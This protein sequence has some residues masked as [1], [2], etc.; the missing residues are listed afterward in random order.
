MRF[1]ARRRLAAALVPAC[2]LACGLALAAPDPANEL[3]AQMTASLHANVAPAFVLDK[4]LVLDPALREAADKIGAEHLARVD[5]LFPAWLEEERSRQVADGK[6]PSSRDVFYA[7]FA[8]LMN[9]MSLWQ[10]EPGDP[11]YERATL[12]VLRTAAGVCDLQGDDRFTDFASRILR[13][14]AMPPAQRDAA[15]GTER[16][17]L[18][19]WGQP[20]AALAPWPDPLPQDA[21]LALLERGPADPAHPR[22][23]LTPRMAAGVLGRREDY[24]HMHPVERCGLQQWWL[25]QSLREGTAPTTALN[26]F[27]YGTMLT[28]VD[29][30]GT[31]FD[32][33][34]QDDKPAPGA[35]PRYPAIALRFLATGVNTVRLQ[36]DAD[37]R[38]KPSVVERR[39]EVVGIRGV[40]PV[41]FENVF[42]Q[43]LLTFAAANPG[44]FPKPSDATP[45]KFQ[46]VWTLEDD[47]P[48]AKTG[49]KP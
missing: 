12:A 15:L 6:T 47:K 37:G 29:R 44:R 43:A 8:R 41:A 4:A 2:A 33:A 45:P 18:A 5:K 21:A 35:A 34:G 40:R 7:V 11:A 23:A 36:V 39:I 20:R 27:R 16:Q 38:P 32:K 19:H 31:A 30:I 17:L 48:A 1:T 13:I 26:A 24:A 22:L 25:Q 49:A 46:W 14:Q 10:L 28:A 42:D 9:E 3:R